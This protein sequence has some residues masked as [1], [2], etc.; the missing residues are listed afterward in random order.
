MLHASESQH[1]YKPDGSPC[2]QVESAKGGLRPATL[3]DARKL[4]LFPSVTTILKCADK[5]GLNRW[6]QEQV[7][8]AA[9]T[10][11]RIEGESESAL[12]ARIWE[13]SR[14]QSK[15][16]ADRGTA[17]HASLQ[18]HYEGEQPPQ[19]HW[20][21]VKATAQTIEERYGKQEWVAEKSFA[22]EMGFAG[23]VDL[24]CKIAVIDFKTKEFPADDLPKTWDEHA[25]QL[26]AYRTG[27]LIPDAVGAIAYV[28]TSTP[29]LVHLSELTGK[30]MEKG[31]DC[32]KALLKYWQ[33]K[34]DYVPAI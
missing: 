11:P 10:L 32:F 24:H 2:Y 16:A 29:G 6:M 5:P 30:E 7:L 1:W 15:A 31:W 23:K 28:S 20:E 4:N 14:A 13:D 17:I 22:H 27:L 34:N 8:H 25:M 21:Y 3:R 12:L 19:E 9:L 33:A 18:G 26:A